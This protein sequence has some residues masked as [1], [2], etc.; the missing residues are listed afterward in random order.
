MEGY[1]IEFNG[2]HYQSVFPTKD[3]ESSQLHINLDEA[4]FYMVEEC[5]VE[6][7][8]IKVLALKSFIEN[9][10]KMRRSLIFGKV[11]SRSHKRLTIL[12]FKYALRDGI[13]SE[14]EYDFYFI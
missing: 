12:D 7:S 1:F 6:V 11:N 2:E 13:I 10:E 3:A 14:D 8:D 5:G 4:F 9:P